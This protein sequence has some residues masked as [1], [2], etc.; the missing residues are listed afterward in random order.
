MHLERIKPGKDITDRLLLVQPGM[1][2]VSRTGRDNLWSVKKITHVDAE[3]GYATLEP[4][5]MPKELASFCAKRKKRGACDIRHIGQRGGVF[6]TRD[7]A[8]A[9]VAEKCG[10]APKKK[11][12]PVRLSEDDDKHE[13]AIALLEVVAE[14]GCASAIGKSRIRVSLDAE[15]VTQLQAIVAEAIRMEFGRL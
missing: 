6:D 5:V 9:Y 8:F 7:E 14:N 11:E 13:R 15:V 2:T 1:Y 10:L 3:T 12:E 4:T